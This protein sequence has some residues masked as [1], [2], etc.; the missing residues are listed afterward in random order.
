MLCHEA[1]VVVHLLLQQPRCLGRLAGDG[2]DDGA[3]PLVVLFK[4]KSS[5]QLTSDSIDPPAILRLLS[6]NFWN[7]EHSD[8]SKKSR[9]KPRCLSF[10]M[11]QPRSSLLSGWFRLVAEPAAEER[12]LTGG[13]RGARGAGEAAGGRSEAVGRKRARQIYLLQW[14]ENVSNKQQWILD[15]EG[16]FWLLWS[17]WV[18]IIKEPP[19]FMQLKSF[20]NFFQ[21]FSSLGHIFALEIGK[22]STE[23]VRK[24]QKKLLQAST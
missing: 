17:E 5:H 14:K 21:N 1:G 22:I 12:G 20:S 19:V 3:P 7:T 9:E 6:L 15:D 4:A 16:R 18:G 10:S 24:L 8:V 23:W 11:W 13:S 2:G